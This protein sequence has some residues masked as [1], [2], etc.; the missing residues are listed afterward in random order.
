MALPSFTN[1]VRFL[2]DPRA[3][4]ERVCDREA[5]YGAFSMGFERWHVL[6]GPEGNAFF[7]DL[8]SEDADPLAFR[9][10]M[11]TLHLPG[12]PAPADLQDATKA[13]RRLLQEHLREVGMRNLEG[14]F[15]RDSAR[16]VAE[17]VQD[18]ST[19]ALSETLLAA[20]IRVVA[21]FVFGTKAC[22]RL[23]R[24]L[25]ADYVEIEQSVRPAGPSSAR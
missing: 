20:C 14:C 11:P 8:A 24:H 7:F 5:G 13:A 19:V 15:A 18:G 12:V 10:R 4:L 3:F 25:F 1:P 23:P 9:V 16:A 21:A 22:S 2:R 6:T 17:L